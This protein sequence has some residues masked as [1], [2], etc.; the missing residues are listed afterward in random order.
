MNVR[1]NI[2]LDSLAAGL[3]PG[4]RT[5]LKVV[6]QLAE[7]AELRVFLVGGPV[8]DALLGM[9]VLDLDLSVVGDA[10]VLASSLANRLDGNLTV[11]QRFGTAT[12]NAEEV[13]IDLVTARS[14]T[15][16]SPGALPLVQPG[17]IDDDLARR[18]FTINAMALPV[19]ADSTFV[20]DPTG[21]LDDLERRAIKILHSRSFVDDPTRMLRAVRYEQ[22]FGFRIESGTLDSLAAARDSGLMEAVSGDRWRHELE[23]ILEEERP[24]P[25]LLRAMELGL[26]EGIHPALTR[27][28]GLRRLASQPAES[29]RSDDWLASLFASLSEAEGEGAIERLRLAGSWAIVARDTISIRGSEAAILGAGKASLLARILSGISPEAVS[30]WT[31]LTENP[32]VAATLERFLCELRGARTALSG[33]EL[34]DMG[35]PQGPVVGEILGR[36]REAKLD[37]LVNGEEEERALAMSL[38]GEC[39]VDVA[40]QG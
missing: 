28:D 3:E 15:Y 18:D 29:V 34:L 10:T 8:R 30:A 12:V 36:L 35:V 6:R 16:E 14:E 22:R 4:R 25:P 38:L 31:R 24:G 20:V 32:Q 23:R 27:D 13:R 26:L 1:S 40:R 21:G 19:S 7:E 17:S 2:S 39:R 37:G 5:A 9:P 33:Q 11:H